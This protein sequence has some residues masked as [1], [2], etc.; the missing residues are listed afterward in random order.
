[1]TPE[2]STRRPARVAPRVGF[3][4]IL[5]SGNLGND[6]SL[7]AVVMFLRDRLPDV[8][9]GFLC[10]G[11]EQVVER[12]GAPATS[13]QW[14]EAH[15]GTA[16]GARAVLLKIVGKLLDPFRTFVWVYRHDVVIVP[17]MGVLE[18][19]LPL[20]PWAFPYSLLWLCVSARLVGTRVALV[21]VGAN[22][23]RKRA[24]R[25]MITR[26]ARLAHYRSYRDAISRDAMREMG[27]DVGADEVYPDL[28]FALPA[29]PAGPAT[30]RAVGVGVMA[31]YGGND[32]RRRADQL[33]RAYVD[34]MKGFVRW[35]VDDGRHVRLFTGDQVDESVV[36]EILSDLQAHRPGLDLSRVVAEPASTLQDLMRHMTT[37]D[38]VVATRY[39][40]VL[41]ALKLCKPT[42]S[43]GYAAKNDVL[44]AGMGLGE[45]CQPARSV[46]LEH[47]IAQ[48]STLESRR[49]QVVDTMAERNR[50][51][52]RRLDQQFAALS[53]MVLGTAEPAA[54]RVAADVSSQGVS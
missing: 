33:H 3:C 5:G 41:C 4:G 21:S 17:G 23:I 51:N 28:A 6:G 26:A 9:L 14:Y 11:P 15:A 12:Y 1:V 40:N 19:T 30:P 31:Y 46:D 42:L 53:A 13:L 24:T 38:A 29:P 50:A 32:D 48:F 27:V 54:T 22:A 37:V 25:W 18:A 47:L 20:R 49:E 34:T 8:S 16:T 36:T 7:D 2:R 39:H 35:L 52:V 43:I 45:F 44:M 10:M